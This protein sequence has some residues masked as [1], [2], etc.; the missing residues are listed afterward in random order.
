MFIGIDIGGTKCAVVK[1]DSVGGVVQKIKFET[2]DLN[3]TL[4]NIFDAVAKRGIILS[5]PNLPWLNCVHIC[6]ILKS[7]FGI[8]TALQNDAKSF[9]QSLAIR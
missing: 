6:D 1:G 3:G 2:T 7:H 5:P 8:P 9:L 4:K